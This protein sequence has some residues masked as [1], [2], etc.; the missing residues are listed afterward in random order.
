[1]LTSLFYL[2]FDI[3]IGRGLR[4][5]V[6]SLAFA[7]GKFDLL[8]HLLA[9]FLDYT[10]DP[11]SLETV[12]LSELDCLLKFVLATLENDNGLLYLIFLGVMKRNIVGDEHLLVVLLKLS[13]QKSK[14][15]C[16][17]SREELL[18]RSHGFDSLLV[19]SNDILWP[20]SMCFLV[21][22]SKD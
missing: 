9:Q 7:H 21:S 17:T 13:L 10:F 4:L 15:I 5:Q 22:L 3:I 18:L 19:E 16:I 6:S 20:N 11:F 14:W 8:E 1:M 2:H 12:L